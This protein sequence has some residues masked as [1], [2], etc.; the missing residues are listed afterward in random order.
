[1]ARDK[2]RILHVPARFM[3]L[4]AAGLWLPNQ[5]PAGDVETAERNA[6]AALRVGDVESALRELTF[7][8]KAGNAEAQFRLAALYRIGRGVAPNDAAAFEWMRQAAVNGHVEA[9][10]QLGSFYL[11]GRGT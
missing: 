10:A 5:A 6:E 2:R 3:L 4:V 1:M 9:Q 11:Q 7:A 8:A